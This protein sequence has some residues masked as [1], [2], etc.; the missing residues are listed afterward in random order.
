MN[1]LSLMQAADALFVRQLEGWTLARENYAALASVR[2]RQ[3]EVEGVPYRL[4]YNP[5][6][7]VS[8]AA[9]VDAQS[10]SRRKCFLCA[11]NLPPE[12]ERLEVEGD[13][14]LLVNP[15]PIFPRHFTIAAKQHRPQCVE[16][17]L[18]SMFLLAREL[19]DCV[20]FYNGPCCGASAPDHAH[21]QAGNKGFLPVEQYWRQ[22]IGG[23]AAC[24]GQS[25]LYRIDDAPRCS[26]VI[27]ADRVEDGMMLFRRF[28]SALPVAEGEREPKMNLLCTYHPATERWT[29]YIFP[30][31]AHRPA[32]YYA[33]GD[34]RI[35]CSPG[36]VDMGGVIILP[37]EEDF[38]CIT[39]G[40]VQRI[41]A[42][43]SL[44]FDAIQQKIQL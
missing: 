17:M 39:N 24:M 27:D 5:A 20:V 4:Q 18:H 14:W 34:A 31:K 7:I 13:Y 44:P 6:R 19:T 29:L 43:V 1:D 8:S 9:K 38:N 2:V 35:L 42:E 10:V 41:L 30:R 37:R 32:C 12:Q 28:C 26:W 23:T 15:Y 25:V 3:V 40:D 21:L 16:G 11:E 22:H 36:A 33:E